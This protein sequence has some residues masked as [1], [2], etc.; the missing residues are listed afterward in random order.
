MKTLY[1]YL[2]DGKLSQHAFYDYPVPDE[3]LQKQAK[4][5]YG[6]NATTLRSLILSDNPV[7]YYTFDRLKTI[8]DEMG[9]YD[10][11]VNGYVDYTK[12]SVLI[13][14]DIVGNNFLY[15][16]MF[17]I[18]PVTNNGTIEFNFKTTGSH[19]QSVILSEWDSSTGSG[20]YKFQ[21]EGSNVLKCYVLDDFHYVVG[22][23][24]LNEF[25]FVV[26]VITN[27]G[28]TFTMYINNVQVSSLTLDGI[29]EIPVYGLNRM[30]IGSDSQGSELGQ[31]ESPT[32]IDDVAFYNSEL[33]V[34][35]Q[36]TQYDQFLLKKSTLINDL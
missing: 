32:W 33:I 28:K 23:F 17:H 6:Y 36:N 30:T 12:N 9:N 14:K 25:N 11:T 22:T 10:L 21:L 20:S 8:T 26:L 19:T 18:D 31:M 1:I 15:N 35:R 5:G 3:D 27:S 13:N 34:S 24:N 7:A 16:D 4:R 29:T 2:Q